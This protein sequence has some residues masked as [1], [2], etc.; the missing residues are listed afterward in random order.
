MK[1]AAFFDL[2][3]TLIPSPS[4]EHRFFR[5]AIARRKLRIS[6]AV[7]WLRESITLG[8]TAFR[9]GSPAKLAAIDANKS[10]VAG[11]PESL[12]T[13]WVQ[14]YAA[15]LVFL[16]P[17]HARI[18]WHLAQD[19]QIF[20]VSGSLAPLVRAAADFNPTLSNF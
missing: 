8:A 14:R 5:F 7:G 11:I 4:P 17:A 20:I 18:R 16:D 3:G 19:H 6:V 13:E 12:A 9:R 2:D 1:I 15:A 10:W